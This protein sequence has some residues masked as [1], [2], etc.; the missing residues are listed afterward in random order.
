MADEPTPEGAADGPIEP[1]RRA[2]AL[3][4]RSRGQEVLHPSRAEYVDTVRALKEEGFAL[5]VDVTAVDY[6][7]HPPRDLSLIH[8]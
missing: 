2:G 3:V 7:E 6:L 1:E 5:C 8:I 4:T